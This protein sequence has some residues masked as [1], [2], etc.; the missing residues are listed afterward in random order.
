MAVIGSFIFRSEGDGILTG[1][2]F[3]NHM[4]TPD[5]ECCKIPVGNPRPCFPDLFSGTYTSTW[6]QGNNAVKAEL[7]IRKGTMFPAD[8]YVLY[9]EVDGALK[10][11][12][13]GIL[14]GKFLKGYYMDEPTRT[15]LGVPVPV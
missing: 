1:K 11:T 5:P 12:G 14:H 10:F 4:N 9:W 3:N 13:R 2:Y 15:H 7:E 8:Y 6:L